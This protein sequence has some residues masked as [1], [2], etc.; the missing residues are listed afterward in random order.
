MSDAKVILAD[1]LQVSVAAI[2]DDAAI[3]VTDQWDSLAHM[4][5]ILAVEHALGRT[6]DTDVM[7]QLDN[8]AAIQALL[9]Q[10]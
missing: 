4:H 10:G 2:S 6:L 1:V 5:L 8:L 9:N 3:G 7:L